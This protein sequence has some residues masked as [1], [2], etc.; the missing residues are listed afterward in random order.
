MPNCAIAGRSG[1]SLEPP[2]AETGRVAKMRVK[3]RTPDAR[4]ARE[5]LAP[6]ELTRVEAAAS[7][8]AYG[9]AFEGLDCDIV[10]YDAR[11][12]SAG[13]ALEA[14]KLRLDARAPLVIA[15]AVN[16]AS[17]PA[18]PPVFDLVIPVDGPPQ[19]IVR[20]L[21]EGLRDAIGQTELAARD[22][23]LAALLPQQPPRPAEP[24][25][26]LQ[27]LYAG[28]PHAAFLDLEQAMH[29]NGIGF[30][31]CLSI[32]A[33]FDRL[34]ERALDALIVNLEGSEDAGLALCGALRRNAAL[35]GMPA[36]ALTT[37]STLITSAFAKGA[38]EA[39]SAH[40]IAA[41]GVVWLAY[42]AQRRRHRREV[43]AR[44][45][46]CQI[47][48]DAINGFEAHLER[49]VRGHFATDR[50][51]C[52]AALRFESPAG[53]LQTEFAWRK[54]RDEALD[55]ARRLVRA[56]DCAAILGP[57]EIVWMLPCTPLAEAE[58]LAIRA[59]G[60]LEHTGFVGTAG[61]IV[62]T[63]SVSELA[64]GESSQAL[65]HRT[66][67]ACQARPVRRDA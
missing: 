1:K 11:S 4:V 64:P 22:A 29:K 16:R 39:G 55:M 30:E 61:P 9:G 45:E 5:L 20:L 14:A 28:K 63:K 54:Q 27:A 58:R 51:L 23:T 47:Q 42:F 17:G 13:A 15:G 50:A 67:T 36:A 62:I 59:V 52:L 60:V 10:L 8:G 25:T 44:L 49:V 21:E 40:D 37:T 19:A 56:A 12:F 35:Q 53:I 26:A 2:R 57:S 65:L 66:R 48:I 34:H 32:S 31:A 24:A 46:H 7:L 33:A 43:Q 18:L 38:L 3:I 6:F 41:H